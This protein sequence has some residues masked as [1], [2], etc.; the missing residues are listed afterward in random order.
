MCS[1]QQQV[2]LP[3][4]NSHHYCLFIYVYQDFFCFIP[5]VLAVTIKK[6]AYNYIRKRPPRMDALKKTYCAFSPFAAS[7]VLINS[8]FF[9]PVR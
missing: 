1:V 9:S 5:L 2:R 7:L 4:Q 3:E 6:E 8:W